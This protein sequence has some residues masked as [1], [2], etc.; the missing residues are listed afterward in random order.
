MSTVATGGGGGIFQAR[1]GALYVA[2]MLTGLPT[3][4]SLQGARVQELR[5]EA[6]YTGA[7]TD[8]IYCRISDAKGTQLQLIQCK[9]G[10]NATAGDK[11]F[12][13]GLQGAWRDFLGLENSPF[14]RACDILVLATISSAKAANQAAKCLC[15]LAR[16]S[17]DLA[18]FLQKLDSNL[19]NKK[20]KDTWS[21]FKTISKETLIEKYTEELVFQLLRRLRI[22][23]HDL[24]VDSSQELSLVQALLSSGT[25]NDSGELVWDGLVSYVQEQGITAGTITPSTWLSTAKEGLRAAVSRLTSSSGLGSIAERLSNR[26]QTQ[27]SLIST[28][29]PNGV[30]VN[31]SESVW[32]VLAGF[33]ERQLVVLT[34]GPGAGK[35]AVVSEL[36]PLLRESGPLLF[37]KAEDLGQPSLAAMQSL[38]GLPDPLL[39]IDAL[40][41]TAQPT[42]IIDSLEKALE[43]QN[44]GALEELLALVRKNK[45]ARLCITTR[46][47]ALNGLYTHF[48]SSFSCQIV[49][50]PLLTDSEMSAAVAGSPL[51][52]LISKDVGVR[53]VL[54]APY[55]LELAF[56]SINTGVVLLSSSENDLRRMLWT[57]RV[58]PSTGLPLGLSRRR[59]IAFDAVCYLRT[60]RF[61]QFVEAPTDAEAVISLLQDAVLL[62]DEA[63]R[64]APAHDVLEDWA[65]FFQVERE[66]RSAERDWTALFKKLGVHAGM[67]RA[68]RSWTAQKSAEGDEDAFAL[69]QAALRPESTIPQLWCDE[70]AIGLLRSE[71]VE[72]LI[73]KLG[74]NGSFNNVALLQRLSHLL[75]VA[76]KGPTSIDYSY[77]ADDPAN[78]EHL[79][80]IGMAAPVGKAW[81]V[82]IGLIAMTFPTLP[83]E[84]HSWVAQLAE[85]AIA[86]DPSWYQPSQRVANVFNIA[87]HYCSRDKESWYRG[88]S[89]GKRF[90]ALLCRCSGADPARFKVFVDTLIERISCDTN[91]RDFYAEERLEFLTNV[92]HCREPAY[93]SPDLVR[94]AFCALY[95]E[96]EPRRA[97]HH[98]STGWE[99]SLGLSDRAAHK[100]FPP[101]TLQGP[102]RS[103]L[104]YSFVKSVHFVVELCNHAAT[105]F[106][107]S[108]PEEITVISFDKSPNGRPHICGWRFWSAYRGNSVSSDV[109]KCALMA[110]EERLLIDAKNQPTLVSKA[111]ELI[112][113]IGESSFTTGLVAG[114]LMA[115]PSLVTQRMLSIFKY[116]DFFGDDIARSV[117]EASALAIHGGHDG[118]DKERQKERMA[119]NQLPHRRQHLET[120]VLQL[121]FNRSDLRDSIFAILDKHTKDLEN[122]IGASDGWRMGLKRMDV[123]GLK[124]G[125]PLGEERLLPLEIAELAPDLKVASDKA[126]L[127]N[128]LM[129]RLA[130]LRLWAGA[131]TQP[132]L[133]SAQG[134]VDRFSSAAEVYEEFIFLREE[135]KGQGDTMLFGLDDEL[136]CALIQR[137]PTDSSDALQW[138]KDYLLDVTFH[139]Q[140]NDAWLRSD[141]IALELRAKTLILLASLDPT[142]PRVAEALANVITEPVWKVRRSAAIAISEVLR[143]KQPLVS[144]ILTTGLAQYAEA[145]ETSPQKSRDFVDE[146]RD[147]KRKALVAALANAE[148][149]RRPEPSSLG[150]VKEWTI[151]LDAARSEMPETWRVQVLTTLARLV[152]D[153]EGKPRLDRYDSDYVDFDARLELGDLLAA[154]LLGQRT[155]Q[156]HIFEVLDYCI[157]NAP[158]LSERVLESTLSGILKREYAN[159]E[160][161]WRVWDRAAGKILSDES[162]RTSSRRSYSKYEKPLAVLL[163]G[164]MRWPISWHDIPLLQHR[165]DFVANCLEVAGDSRYALERLLALMAGV[166]RATAVPSALVQ[167]RDAMRRAPA[168]IFDNGNALWDA[169]TVCQV[170]V[171]EHRQVLLRN[172]NLRMST[173]D[174]L[175]CLV[176]AGSSL[177]FQL[178]DYLA[179]SPIAGGDETI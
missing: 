21:A 45:G 146:V 96:T 125:E 177:A 109:L 64:V 129:N 90:Y 9:R 53:E 2:N 165:P 124:F 144:N 99:E 157:E 23:I 60:E 140:R 77:L 56:N 132:G 51:D 121:Q 1:V 166:G 145:L 63:E 4:F 93:F 70:V 78:K 75:R 22:D 137:W 127:H 3:A 160:A 97:R 5:F 32:R 18:D 36:A 108:N 79:A 40:L 111:L 152:A 61:A 143:I 159:A 141:Y 41:S 29:L 7:H 107:K 130:T 71:R 12:I 119:S 38:S 101:S 16:A 123:R 52:E 173:L 171:H 133:S 42:V 131:V 162:L 163:F 49:E 175:D 43:A 105:S 62:Q 89:I 35:S 149:G 98:Y 34:G 14:D 148:P 68:L 88:Q 27:L 126:E 86:H 154:E 47:Y 117:G 65:L 172:V 31:R 80:R 122:T 138:A 134:T 91:H 158:E 26:A 150:A 115:N 55:Y 164:T 85:D 179:T 48:L 81:D 67:R 15:E 57:E 176:I 50:V 169:E 24:A 120:L 59:Q 39:G 33:E 153:Q 113:E 104:L 168:D 73:E 6:R 17:I 92:K 147:A 8:D 30:H 10:L 46:S 28:S 102:F 151:A 103:L 128:Q 142:L 118:L 95:I 170:A 114:V 116:P 54:R 178:R 82:M 37:F 156:T 161:F 44:S 19:F 66:V 94:E 74:G 136:P 174:I 110:L 69:L 20:H 87:E 106:A 25:C 11:D 135:F 72:D 83:P 139:Y 112:L 76:C 13:D 84:A 100:F 155:D 167:L 58:A